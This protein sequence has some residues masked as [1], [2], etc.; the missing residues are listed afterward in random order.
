MLRNAFVSLLA[1]VLALVGWPRGCGSLL[2]MK[3]AL[4]FAALVGI[5][6][7]AEPTVYFKDQFDGK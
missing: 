5:A 6:F 7:A 2:R 1:V 3:G 4:L